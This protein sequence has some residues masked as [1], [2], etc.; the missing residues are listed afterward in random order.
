MESTSSNSKGTATEILEASKTL[1]RTLSSF[2]SNAAD[3]RNVSVQFGPRD[4][5]SGDNSESP[6]AV[7]IVITLE[8]DTQAHA[9]LHAAEL[10][11]QGATCESSGETSVT[12]HY[13]DDGHE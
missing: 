10:E 6:K 7:S 2:K 9:E 5:D 4:S 3:I 13:E 11:A 1:R 8:A 12:C